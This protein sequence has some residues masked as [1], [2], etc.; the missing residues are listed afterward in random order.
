MADVSVTPADVRE[1]GN[2]LRFI[3]TEFEGSESIASDYAED[4]GHGGLAG[5]LERFAENWHHKRRALMENLQSFA[6]AA[7][8][9]ADAFDGI[10]DELVNALEGDG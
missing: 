3:A 7:K 1:L 4:V 2:Q 10:E 5:E 8:Q 6:E 9:S